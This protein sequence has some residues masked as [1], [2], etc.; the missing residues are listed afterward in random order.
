MQ[1]IKINVHKL[2]FK[3]LMSESLIGKDNEINLTSKSKIAPILTSSIIKSSPPC[4]IPLFID[5]NL[6]DINISA[7]G[8]LYHFHKQQC[9]E[10]ILHSLDVGQNAWAAMELWYNIY[11]VDDDDYS[12]ESMY[13]EWQRYYKRLNHIDKIQKTT[14][15][16]NKKL[17]KEEI[18]HISAL[19]VSRYLE[20]FY[21]RRGDKWMKTMYYNLY[22]YIIEYTQSTRPNKTK[23]IT[24]MHRYYRF[25]NWLDTNIKEKEYLNNLIDNIFALK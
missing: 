17:T 22:A 25:N 3:V 15:K 1:R 19:F 7:G 21:R 16:L 4:D 18:D 14:A 10:Y 6:K 9:L 23:Y 24:H 20:H 2:S 13:R 5:T 11:D 12:Q 8:A